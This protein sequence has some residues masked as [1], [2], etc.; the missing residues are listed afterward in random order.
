MKKK[1]RMLVTAAMAATLATSALPTILASAAET[2]APNQQQ[3]SQMST[4]PFSQSNLEIA[5][6]AALYGPE[7]KKIKVFEHEF[8]VKPIEV[9]NLGGGK[10]Y[11]KGQI[12]HHLTLR[13]DDQF[14]YEF[15]VKDGKVTDTPKFYIDRGGFTPFAAPLLSIIAA[16]NG[17][18]VNPNDLNTLG[19][20]IGR[21]I[22]GSWEHAAQSIATIVS[23]TFNEE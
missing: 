22:D 17:I 3:E 16:Y 14:Y 2:N 23:L 15:T 20:Q 21:V 5:V 4:Q 8:N 11:I 18:P 9:V 6:N 19:Q 13:P 10:Q 7:V 1:Q 12:S